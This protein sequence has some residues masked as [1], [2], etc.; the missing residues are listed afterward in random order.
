MRMRAGG[1]TPPPYDLDLLVVGRPERSTV[2]AAAEAVEQRTGLTV[3]PVIASVKRWDD[4]ADPLITEIKSSP[5]VEIDLR[6]SV[7]GA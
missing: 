2:Y 4:D 3:N 1:V 5:I 6:Q 7:V